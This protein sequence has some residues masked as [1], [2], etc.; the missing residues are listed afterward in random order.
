M[1]YTADVLDFLESTLCVDTD[2]IYA[3][4][5]SNGGG[6]VAL[7]S[8]DNTM[9]QRISAFM[10][11]SGAYYPATHSPCNPGK[12]QVPFLEFHGDADTVVGVPFGRCSMVSLLI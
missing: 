7:L 3:T 12:A 11:A 5:K 10:S 4:G 8:C 6:F 2:R 1:Q 9:T